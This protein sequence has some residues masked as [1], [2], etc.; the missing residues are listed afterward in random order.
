MTKYGMEIFQTKVTKVIKRN[1][2]LDYNCMH[3]N[4][5]HKLKIRC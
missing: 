2:Y 4:E 3:I 5:R 1:K